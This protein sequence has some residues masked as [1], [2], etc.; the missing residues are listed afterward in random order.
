MKG[1]DLKVKLK[2]MDERK[3]M[4]VGKEFIAGWHQA[5]VELEIWLQYKG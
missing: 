2:E 5:I 4:F 1:N 3:L